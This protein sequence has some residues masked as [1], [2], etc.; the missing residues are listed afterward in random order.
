MVLL[1]ANASADK[2]N[3]F[4]TAIGKSSF[5]KLNDPGC[6]PDIAPSNCYLLS[7]SNKFVHDKNFSG[8]DERIDTIEDYLNKLD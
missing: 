4:R 3:I 2:C 5:V 7:N 6:F 8:D 1:H